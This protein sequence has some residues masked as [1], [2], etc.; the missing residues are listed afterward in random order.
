MQ[1]T[2]CRRTLTIKYMGLQIPALYICCGCKY[3]QITADGVSTLTP[4]P[5]F[6][7]KCKSCGTVPKYQVV[8][9]RVH[10]DCNVYTHTHTPKH[11]PY[12]LRQQATGSRAGKG[13]CQ[14]KRTVADGGMNDC[15]QVLAPAFHCTLYI[16]AAPIFSLSTAF[17]LHTI[18][19]QYDN[20]WMF[21][22]Q[23]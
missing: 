1:S 22:W 6:H 8:R 11:C 2:E 18:S 12:L 20:R 17:T 3:C 23:Q 10:A 13:L 7:F 19:E 5:W 21:V 14:Y 16:F 9:V 15:L 4:S